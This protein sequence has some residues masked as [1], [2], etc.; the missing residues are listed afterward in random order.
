MAPETQPPDPSRVRIVSRE[1][2][3]HIEERFDPKTRK[4]LYTVF[5]LFT[6]DD[7]ECWT[8]KLERRAENISLAHLESALRRVPDDQIYPAMPVKP[9]MALIV[10]PK[11][12]PDDSETGKFHTARP[13]LVLD[14][15]DDAKLKEQNQQQ[16]Q[17]I[18]LREAIVC[19]QLVQYPHPNMIRYH[20]VRTR[21]GR[22]TGLVFDRHPHS[23]WEYL[24]LGLMPDTDKFMSQL[25]SGVARLHRLGLA[26]NNIKP[27]NVV[28]SNGG[29]RAVLVNFGNC[30]PWGKK[31][32]VLYSG[33]GGQNLSTKDN[34]IKGLRQL[35]SW[36]ENPGDPF[37]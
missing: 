17:Q 30:L 20:G 35:R 13:T 34:D 8:G 18:L 36:L 23:L 10:A 22:I 6:D 3:H 27:E 1:D 9:L 11:T 12:P 15:T 32:P 25:E 2:L 26:H 29:D 14:D 7:D 33:S 4:H 31:L 37:R 28:V 21:R 24:Q 19:Q 16:Q 5:Y